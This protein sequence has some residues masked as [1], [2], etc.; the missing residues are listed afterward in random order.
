MRENI[1][2]LIYLVAVIGFV[3]S[4][5]WMTAVSTARRGILAGEAGF[6]LLPPP[7]LPMRNAA[8]GAAAAR[9][10]RC[11]VRPRQSAPLQQEC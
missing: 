1:I 2:Q 5:K 8:A 7:P 4:L 3:L 10:R 11:R 9:A 6:I